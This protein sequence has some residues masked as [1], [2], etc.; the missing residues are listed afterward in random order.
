MST[1]ASPVSVTPHS[2]AR[3]YA[4][5]RV[6]ERSALRLYA[7]EFAA[8]PHRAYEELRQYSP[9]VPVEVA[10]GVPA[11]LVLDYRQAL[12]ILGDPDHFPADHRAWRTTI[13]DQCPV[14]PMMEW[15]PASDDSDDS[16][17]A[18]SA[19]TAAMESIDLHALRAAVEAAAVPLINAFCE[20]GSADLLG[21]YARPLTEQVLHDLLGLP[22]EIRDLVHAAMSALN[23]TT[24]PESSDLNEQIFRNVVTQAVTAK[25]H[26]P[27]QDAISQLLT[28]QAGFDDSEVV[29]LILQLYAMGSEPTWNL[30]VNTL[31]LMATDAGFHD[32][33]VSGAIQVRDA[34]D[35]VLFTDPPVQN[36]CPRYPRQP[37]IIGNVWLPVNQPVLIS[38][39]ACNNDPAISGDRAGNRA[40]LAWGAGPHSCPAQSVAIL[41]VQEAIDQLLDALPE[42]A[43]AVPIEELS[44]HPSTFH[45]APVAIPVTFPPAPPLT[46]LQ[47]ANNR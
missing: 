3:A 6:A 7:P 31:L 10:A 19:Y 8:D 25:R 18:R 15:G 39:T 43:L 5:E 33:L 9:A 1:D 21:Q 26:A 17:R 28:H 41:I 27:A 32:G 34:I 35:E 22:S 37:Q 29:E 42:I 47:G 40:H 20:S 36:G 30:I 14:L 2:T 46:F 13:P 44:W 12:R 38:L 24:D 11:M 23:V 16:A 4:P 45:R